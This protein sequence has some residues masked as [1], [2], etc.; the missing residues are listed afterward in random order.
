MPGEGE[1]VLVV[2]LAFPPLFIKAL[3]DSLA[4]HLLCCW[5]VCARRGDTS[6][7]WLPKTVKCFV[8]EGQSAGYGTSN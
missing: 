5:S 2:P 8:S 7:F 4:Q 3:Q 6:F 1:K